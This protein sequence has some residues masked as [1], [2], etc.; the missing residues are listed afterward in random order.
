MRMWVSGTARAAM[1]TASFVALGATT[2]LGAGS[3]FADS[4]N[5]DGSVLGGNQV[6]APISVP[7]NISGNAVGAAGHAHANSVGG[8]SVQN[9]SNGSGQTTSGKGSVL[10]GNQVNAPV[11]APINACGNAIAILGSSG[12]GCKGGATVANQGGSAQHTSGAGSVLGGNQVNAPIS[13]PIDACGNAIAILG[14]AEAGCEGGATVA[15]RGSGGQ[16]TVG[17]NQVNA[18]VSAP[19]DIC[20]NAV[21]LFGD[22]VASC[23][24]GASVHNGDGGYSSGQRT[25]GAG[26]VLGGNQVNAPVSAPVNVCGNAIGG[27][28]A[29]CVGGTSVTNRG[30]G[31]QTTSGAGSV[32]GGNQVHAPVG[33]PINVCGNAGAV[34]GDS[35]ALCKGGAS[36]DNGAGSAQHTSGAGSVLG[37]N[38]VNAPVTAPVNA[39]G[40]AVAALKGKAVASCEGV[41][42]PVGGGNP[43]GC[44]DQGYYS[45]PAAAPRGVA[46][47]LPGL[48]ALPGLPSLPVTTGVIPAGALPVVLGAMPVLPALPVSPGALPVGTPVQQA[49]PGP[50]A[51]GLPALPKVPTTLTNGLPALPKVPGNL[52]NGLPKVPAGL[53]NGLPAAPANLPAPVSEQAAPASLPGLT[54]LPVVGQL[55]VAKTVL[56]NAPV[57]EKLNTPQ[58]GD[59]NVLGDQAITKTAAV[60][61]LSGMNSNTLLALVL[62]GMFAAASTV[63]SIVRRVRRH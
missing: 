14:N 46:G 11:S 52:T 3:A 24:G 34:L 40:N 22:A 19:I 13:A 60:S 48:P 39:C 6:N 18:P 59:P 38:Q 27:H 8:S 25:S 20:G 55:P 9:S 2:A 33:A 23:K 63:T 43:G 56:A 37:G 49:A 42:P 61:P 26:S 51:L 4:T 10:G 54:S 44:G 57:S 15:N 17:G 29:S 62:G 45:A 47:G 21:A 7:V 12:A 50:V 58:L 16:H 5:G 30:S 53:T 1:L 36:V 41:I 35:A 31:D 28:A 32:L